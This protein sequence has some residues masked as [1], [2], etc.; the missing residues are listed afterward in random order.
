MQLSAVVLVV[1]SFASSLWSFKELKQDISSFRYEVLDLL[2]NRKPTRC[3]YS[4][5]SEATQPEAEHDYEDDTEKRNRGARPGVQAQLSS[6][7]FAQAHKRK[8]EGQFTVSALF[9]SMAGLENVNHGP[10]SNGWKKN[11]WFPSSFMKQSVQLRRFS[12]S[13]K[14]SLHHLGSL[15]HRVN[16][17]I[18][19]SRLKSR[20]QQQTYSISDKV[21]QLPSSWQDTPA[22]PENWLTKSSMHLHTLVGESGATN[23]NHTQSGS[24]QA[25]D[26][27][28]LLLKPSGLHCASSLTA[29]SSLLISSSEDLCQG[30]Q[31]PCE[32][33][34]SSYWEQEE[35]ITT[36]L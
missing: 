25:N 1:C 35:S 18:G 2:G 16:G 13:K 33:L 29:S 11:R 28:N 4:S 15:F 26:T 36:Q 12:R 23:K 24:Q 34:D 3:T 9:R 5:S 27:D 8:C 19:E 20:Q 32:S 10:K 30:L 17:H 7:S 6:L 14:D 21:L 22:Q 31:G